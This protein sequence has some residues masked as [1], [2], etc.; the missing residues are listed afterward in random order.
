MARKLYV[1][2]KCSI[3]RGKIIGCAYCDRNGETYVE[4]SDNLLKQWF[5]DQT[6]ERQKELLDNVFVNKENK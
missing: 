4:V 5:L 3:C 1:L 6:E 2:A